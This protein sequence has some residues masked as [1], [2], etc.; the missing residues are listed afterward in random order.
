MKTAKFLEQNRESFCILGVGKDFLHKI[1]K[2]EGE[3]EGDN[4]GK[5]EGF[6]G[7]IIKHTWTITKGGGNRKEVGRAGVVGR[8]GGK[9]Q[10]TALEQQ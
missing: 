1:Q 2:E 6:T 7:T 8:G 9:R 3:R 5:G 4:G 10:K